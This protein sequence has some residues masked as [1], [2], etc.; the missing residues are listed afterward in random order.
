LVG[1]AVLSGCGGD[2]YPD[3]AK[4]KGV[5][6]I[7]GQPAPRGLVQFE[8][9]AGPMA[10][11]A[12]NAQ[13]EYTLTTNPNVPGDGAVFGKH[14]VRLEIRKAPRDETDTTPQSLIPDEYSDSER[15]PLER[16]VTANP[17][18]GWHVFD[19]DLPKRK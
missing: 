18:G 1:L 19:F 15:T 6:K 16:E 12:I 10:V 7:G 11:G 4:V 9:E 8:P 5:I 17:P 3:R 14:K 13:G 2:T